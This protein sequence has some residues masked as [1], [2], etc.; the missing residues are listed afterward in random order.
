MPK[1]LCTVKRA[2]FSVIAS[3]ATISFL[4]AQVAQSSRGQEPAIAAKPLTDD[5]RVSDFLSRKRQR[6][7]ERAAVLQRRGIGGEEVET[8]QLYRSLNVVRPRP[9]ANISDSNLSALNDALG[10]DAVQ[11]IQS[12]G[13]KL[14]RIRRLAVAG[15]DPLVAAT[16]YV[17]GTATISQ[18]ALLADVVAVAKVT[19]VRNELLG[20]GFRSTVMFDV[21]ET[22]SG[23]AKGGAIGASR[24]VWAGRKRTSH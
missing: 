2:T 11:L 8:R 1:L 10:S 16:A 14:Q 9:S 15:F 23:R 21:I 13:I 12:L 4:Q 7:A 22:V 18:Q 6:Q 5:E 19:A 3:L 20:D 24:N 17:R